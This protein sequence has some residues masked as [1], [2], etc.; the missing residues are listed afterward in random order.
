MFLTN[1]EGTGEGKSVY[2]IAV[3]RQAVAHGDSLW[4][5]LIHFGPE[6]EIEIGPNTGAPVNR[7]YLC[8]DRAPGTKTIS[9]YVN[10]FY[11]AKSG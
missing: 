1:S 10:R 7:K 6:L 9:A 11:G 3:W 5:R 8:G 4:H 2:S